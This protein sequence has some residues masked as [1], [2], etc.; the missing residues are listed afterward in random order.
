MQFDTTILA[1][2]GAKAIVCLDSLLITIVSQV[3]NLFS[4]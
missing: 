2:F 1:N 4:K 3:I